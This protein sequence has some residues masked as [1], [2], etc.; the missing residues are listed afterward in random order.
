MT[1]WMKVMEILAA[2]GLNGAV[3]SFLFLVGPLGSF[4]F[5]LTLAGY[6]LFWVA[7]AALIL[8]GII[9]PRSGVPPTTQ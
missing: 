9:Q 5:Q 8:L 4:A 1:R 7:G 3:A 2:I 6:T